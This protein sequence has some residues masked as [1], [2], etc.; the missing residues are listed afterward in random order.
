MIELLT[1][2]PEEVLSIVCLKELSGSEVLYYTHHTILI[3]L[4]PV[5]CD[6]KDCALG[7]MSRGFRVQLKV[8]LG[9]IRKPFRT[10]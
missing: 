10:S 8:L 5:E 3:R 9:V 7:C 1:H 6:I 4:R 2:D